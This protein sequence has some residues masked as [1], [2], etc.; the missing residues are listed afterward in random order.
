MSQ[1][2]A[3]FSSYSIDL[4][5]TKDWD[6]AVDAKSQ[7]Q[8]WLTIPANAFSFRSASEYN[9]STSPTIYIKP[10]AESRLLASENRI[11]STRYTTFDSDS[12]A[13]TLIPG[14]IGDLTSI[15]YLTFS[16][17]VLSVAFELS[18]HPSIATPFA[19]RFTYTANVD[20]TRTPFNVDDI[21]LA[22]LHEIPQIG[23]SA[24]RCVADQPTRYAFP[25][26]SGV[27]NSDGTFTMDGVTPSYQMQASLG[28]PGVYAFILAPAPGPKAKSFSTWIK[29]NLLIVVL[30]SVGGLI[31]IAA[32]FYAMKR[33]HRYRSKYHEERDAVAR[34]RDEVNDME[35]FGGSAGVKD[36]EV[37][38]QSNPLVMQLKD[39]RMAFDAKTNQIKIAETEQR[40]QQNEARAH[41]IDEL[42]ADRDSLEA[43]LAALQAQ[44]S[45]AN[46][47]ITA[48]PVAQFDYVAPQHAPAF[49]TQPMPIADFQG[50]SSSS[51]G[52]GG[53]SPAMDPVVVPVQ[54]PRGDMQ[55]APKQR[56]KDF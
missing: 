13:Q 17:T 50:S 29:D 18:V 38:M 30:A 8:A 53:P 11:P 6:V 49:S 10:I 21:C 20:V 2:K 24:W 55:V 43:E 1:L 15:H 5:T 9:G 26:H 32:V 12:F 35:Q 40:Q 27:R 41:H 42:K 37:E 44:L 3:S 47:S 52:Y 23:F 45:A 31:F 33:F 54:A 36:D 48:R 25:P 34:Q 28:E 46:V 39:M 16:Q 4:S 56:K 19:V 22:R 7:H 51:S 14:F